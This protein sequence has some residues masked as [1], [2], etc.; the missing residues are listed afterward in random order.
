MDKILYLNPKIET[1]LLII[2][3]ILSIFYSFRSIHKPKVAISN[4]S[5]KESFIVHNKIILLRAIMLLVATG[6]VI[7]IQWSVW[8]NTIVS[9]LISLLMI[10]KG[11]P[12]IVSETVTGIETVHFE[13]TQNVSKNLSDK[14]KAFLYYICYGIMLF[15]ISCQEW[16][17]FVISRSVGISGYKDFVIILVV[18]IWYFLILFHTLCVI[19][20][21]FELLSSCIDKKKGEKG[22]R[23]A[24]A[25]G[26]TEKID[27]AKPMLACFSFI[28]GRKR[29]ITRIVLYVLLVPASFCIGIAVSGLILVLD[30][31]ETIIQYVTKILIRII[32]LLRYVFN[33]IKR[34]GEKKYIWVC[35]RFSIMISIVIAVGLFYKHQ[36]LQ[37]S[38]LQI[39]V[40][41]A[42]TLI[43]PFIITEI[44]RIKEVFGEVQIDLSKKRYL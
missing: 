37:E 39:F 25:K 18:I 6:L 19:G 44:A 2:S 17:S 28:S 22:N 34:I 23:S 10:L 27:A 31:I 30:T 24:K 42:E 40:F 7:W 16:L 21:A 38:T 5:E 12:G 15:L 9:R 3:F 14:G 26:I 11:G 33:K 1:V 35:F 36:I 32:R 13:V 43:I 8:K 4:D 20:T 29:R 41:V